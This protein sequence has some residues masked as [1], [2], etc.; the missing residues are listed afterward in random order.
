MND[1]IQ[2]Q[3]IAMPEVS[4]IAGISKSEIF[5]RI[6]INAFPAPARIGGGRCTR[7]EMGEVQEWVRER[8]AERMAPTSQSEQR[9]A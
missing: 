2:L 7:W 9:A 1:G 6:K 3:L 4:R 5:R 8:L